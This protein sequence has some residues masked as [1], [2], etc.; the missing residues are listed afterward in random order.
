MTTEDQALIDLIIAA[1]R[2]AVRAN[3]AG[4]TTGSELDDLGGL[5]D[6]LDLPM[7]A[8]LRK[9]KIGDTVEVGGGDILTVKGNDPKRRELWV[10]ADDD[11]RSSNHVCRYHDVVAV[12]FDQEEA[13]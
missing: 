7:E 6:E 8:A 1:A 12:T 10:G 11:G 2:E 4:E 3:R 13:P 9:L 5:I